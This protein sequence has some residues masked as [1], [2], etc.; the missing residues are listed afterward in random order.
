[1]A[2]KTFDTLQL[3][4][5]LFQDEQKNLLAIRTISDYD[6]VTDDFSEDRII[7]YHIGP[8]TAQWLRE[9]LVWPESDS[10]CR[11][12]YEKHVIDLMLS[13]DPNMFITLQ[14]I[15]FVTC[16]E[17]LDYIL[18]LT[19]TEACEIPSIVDFDDPEALGCTWHYQSSIFINMAAIDKTVL[20][21]QKEFENDGL[22]FN[23]A[24]ETDIAVYTTLAHEIR[25]QGLS[26]PYL[27]ETLYPASEATE[28]AV[29]E[30][31]RQAY[32]N[33]KYKRPK[34]TTSTS[35]AKETLS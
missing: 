25:H 20:E 26:N 24:T 34:S 16:E 13:I 7:N 35:Y 22:F 19:G 18:E 9:R 31:G 12:H 3:V 1:M 33:W 2:T 4:R 15:F 14:H 10:R 8:V 21:L 11:T 6:I 27:D 23:A 28:D 29:E 32:E 5:D 17:D 30:W